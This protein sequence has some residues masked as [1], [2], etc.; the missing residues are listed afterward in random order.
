MSLKV[1]IILE[2]ITL[3]L[4]RAGNELQ[5]SGYVTVYYLL[6]KDTATDSLYDAVYLICATRHEQVVSGI[7]G[8]NC[9]ASAAPVGH[10]HTLKSPL[11]T[12]YAFN[13]SFVL[14]CVSTVYLIV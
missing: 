4:G 6:I 2:L 13:Q 3:H 1:G 5:D 7:D 10:N 8:G 12:K 14:W 11:L 9:I